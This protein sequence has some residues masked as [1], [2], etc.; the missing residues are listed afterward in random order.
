MSAPRT[1]WQRFTT[2]RAALCAL[3][4]LLL[5]VVA[6]FI[7]PT[8][9]PHAVDSID[10]D[11]DWATAPSAINAH[12]FGTDSLGRDVLV[13][14]LSGGQRQVVA[15]SRAPVDKLQKQA[16]RLGW[17]FPWVSS[18]KSTFNYDFN[19]SF[20][21]GEDGKAMYNYVVQPVP[22]KDLQGMSVFAKGPDGAIYHTY[23]TYGR[24]QDL[25]NGAYNMLDLTPKGRDEDGLPFTMAWVKLHDE[26]AA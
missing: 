20:E 26:Y 12:W 4:L 11:G 16:K 23:S 7:G 21:P 17:K 8:L 3:G 14:A 9:S 22:F 25:V 5:I 24:G 6:L 18:G 10:F 1:L 15:I 2:H 13:R 19:V